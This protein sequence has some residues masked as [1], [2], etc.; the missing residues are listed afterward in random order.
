MVEEQYTQFVMS[1]IIGIWLTLR[2][3]RT[4]SRIAL[5][6][7]LNKSSVNTS[8][9]M[10]VFLSVIVQTP[11]SYKST[12]VQDQVSLPILDQCQQRRSGCIKLESEDQEHSLA[13]SRVA[14]PPFL[15]TSLLY[16]AALRCFLDLMYGNGSRTR[17]SYCQCQGCIEV[18]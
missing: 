13:Q 8:R 17:T 7:V 9:L 6:F 3:V 10:F 11:T 14:D 18:P 4:K 12:R 5:A 1:L 15:K 2:S 16:Y